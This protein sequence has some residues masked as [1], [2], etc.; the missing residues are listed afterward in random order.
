MNQQV[1]EMNFDSIFTQ[2]P[3]GLP[4]QP[5][6]RGEKGD[7][8]SAGLPVRPSAIKRIKHPGA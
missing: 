7:I 1:K 4:G 5:G 2:G 3:L 6:A 8:G